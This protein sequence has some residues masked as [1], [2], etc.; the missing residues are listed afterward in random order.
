MSTIINSQIDYT[1]TMLSINHIEKTR[2]GY[3]SVKQ[4][5]SVDQGNRLSYELSKVIDHAKFIYYQGNFISILNADYSSKNQGGKSKWQE[6]LDEIVQN[7][8]TEIGIAKIE[9]EKIDKLKDPKAEIISRLAYRIIRSYLLKQGLFVTCY[10][11]IG[12]IN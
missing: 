1:S 12:G 3:F 5:L 10:G 6:K 11:S 8:H 9:I 7:L 2:I 4:T